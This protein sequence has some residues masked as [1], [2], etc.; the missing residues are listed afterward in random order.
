MKLGNGIMISL[1]LGALAGGLSLKEET[2]LEQQVEAAVPAAASLEEADVTKQVLRFHVR[3]NS[4][5]VVDQGLKLKVKEAVVAYIEP[6]LKESTS[7]ESAIAIIEEEKGNIETIVENT[8]AEANASYDAKVYLTEEYFPLKEYGDL[9]FP[10]GVYQAL[11]ID[12]GMAEG[13]NWWCVMYPTLCM[14]DATNAV[15]PAESKEQLQTV[16]T[17]EEY[18]AL[19]TGTYDGEVTVQ[20]KCKLWEE[21]KEWLQ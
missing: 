19:L 14:I 6:M 7:L 17:R 8:M 9:T 10:A 4:D 15:V 18:E 16:L 3:A 5:T 1:L 21:I 11:R 13:Q 2:C 20:V 12:I